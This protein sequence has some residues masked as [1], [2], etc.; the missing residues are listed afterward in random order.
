M[1][2]PEQNLAEDWHVP[3]CE[4]KKTLKQCLGEMDPF[5]LDPKEVP[6]IIRLIE[7]PKYRFSFFPG[8]VSLLNHDCIHVVLGRGVLLKDEAF[9]IGYMMGSTRK[10]QTLKSKLFLFISKSLYP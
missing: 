3:V 2:F 1:N 10:M 9:V 6:F 8:A 5:K 4:N 7:N